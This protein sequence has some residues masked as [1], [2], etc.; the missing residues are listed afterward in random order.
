MGCT[1]DVADHVLMSNY[2]V[3]EVVIPTLLPLTIPTTNCHS[4]LSEESEYIGSI[5]T[6]SKE[7]RLDRFLDSSLNSE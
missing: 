6:L 3:T 4:E 7:D 5:A 1:G 2:L